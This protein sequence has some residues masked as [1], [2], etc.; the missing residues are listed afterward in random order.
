MSVDA[1]GF[2]N[3]IAYHP[4]HGAVIAVT[5]AK[6][7]VTRFDHN[8][9][10]QVTHRW[11]GGAYPIRNVYDALGR[12]IELHTYRGGTNWNE[13]AWDDTKTGPSDQTTWHFD[14]ATGLLDNKE[15]A[16]GKGPTY[17]YGTAGRVATRT[18]ARTD[19]GGNPLVTT[20]L[21]H[22]DTGGTRYALIKGQALYRDTDCEWDEYRI[23]WM[24]PKDRVADQE[25]RVGSQV[26][27]NIP[28]MGLQGAATVVG[29]QNE[30]RFESGAGG[31]VTMTM[32]HLNAAVYDMRVGEDV[33][34]I[35]KYHPLWILGH[36]WVKAHKVIPGMEALGINGSPVEVVENRKRAGIHRVYNLE[37]DNDHV[38]FVGPSGILVHNS[39][40]DA[41]GNADADSFT[42]THGLRGPRSSRIVNNTEASMRKDGWK[43]KPI[44]VVTDGDSKLILDGHHRVEAAKRTGTRVPYNEIAP[45]DVSQKNS[46]FDNI[47]AA[48]VAAADTK[49]TRVKLK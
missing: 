23:R 45:A 15:Y 29:I 49:A 20:Y 30:V 5:N 33:I 21:Y 3:A 41:D 13:T 32:S 47:D 1:A 19:A 35:T 37:V 10:G 38:Y 48:R 46:M 8:L 43:G 36:D 24:W 39:C 26:P 7:Q 16:D 12:Q 22:P 25:V 44:D 6:G 42:R 34:G 2:T 28:E 40:T 11:G 4:Q 14:N 27:I 9:R 18:W 17:T 31:L